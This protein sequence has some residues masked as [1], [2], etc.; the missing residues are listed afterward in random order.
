MNR[1]PAPS[2]AAINW[3]SA[4]RDI[5]VP[6]GLAGLP[7]R[8]PFKG[9][10]RCAAKRASPVSAWRGRPAANKR[11]QASSARPLG[12]LAGWLRVQPHDRWTLAAVGC[13]RQVPHAVSRCRFKHLYLLN[14]FDPP[15]SR[16]LPNTQDLPNTL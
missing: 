3:V 12:P 8:T 11:V 6:V 4:S 13:R 2:A 10:L 9:V 15:N 16:D 7:T 1:M 5:M 14:P